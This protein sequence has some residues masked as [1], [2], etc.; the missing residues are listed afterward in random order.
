MTCATSECKWISTTAAAQTSRTQATAP[1]STAW[2]AAHSTTSTSAA[3]GLASEAKG[4]AQSQIKSGVSGASVGVDRNERAGWC[5]EGN[6]GAKCSQRGAVSAS[7]DLDCRTRG[8]RNRHGPIVENR[9]AIVILPGGDVVRRSRIDDDER[10]ER[11]SRRHRDVAA[12]KR[13]MAHVESGASVIRQ[14]VILIADEARHRG[15]TASEETSGGATG[16]RIA[17]GIA[18]RVEAEQ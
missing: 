18:E 13:A 7:A 5:R 6:C 9:V 14:W 10:K 17:A 12:N 11:K 1:R 4:L 8:R 3:L 15:S 2:A 16:S